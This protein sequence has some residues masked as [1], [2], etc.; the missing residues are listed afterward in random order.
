[1]SSGPELLELFG[2]GP[3]RIDGFGRDP[4]GDGVVPRAPLGV[5]DHPVV[6]ISRVGVHIDEAR[7]DVEAGSVDNADGPGS[8]HPAHR[9]DAPVTDRYVGHDEGVAGAV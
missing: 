8:V 7:S 4:L 2:Q 6:P 1:M 3:R 5:Q 9:S